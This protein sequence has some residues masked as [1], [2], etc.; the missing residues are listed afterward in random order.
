[1]GVGWM[2][3]RLWYLAQRK[4]GWF[5]F[6]C[7]ALSWTECP[8]AKALTDP[9]L[10]EPSH[11]LA[12]RREERGRFFFDARSFATERERFG[13]W[14][15]EG[16]ESVTATAEAVLRGQYRFFSW[17]DRDLG[18]PPDWHSNL[19]SGRTYPRDVHWSRIDDFA[20]GDVKWPWEL[21]RFPFVF[22]LVRAYARTGDERYPRAF[23]RLVENWLDENPPNLG[24]N[25]KCGQEAALRLMAWLVGLHAFLDAEATTPQLV[26][27]LAQ[28]VHVTGLRIERNLAYAISQDSNH[29]H[30]EVAGLFTIG[31]LFPEFRDSARWE[32]KGRR[33][34][35]RLATTHNYPEGGGCM[36]SVTYL[37]MMVD[38][39][40]WAAVLAD[41]S[42]R[43]LAPVVR[44][45]IGTSAE[46]L[47]QLQD[48]VSGEVPLYGS[49]DGAQ[50]LPLAEC[51]YLDFRPVVQAATVY[52]EGRRR[53]DAGPWDER[54]WWMHGRESLDLPTLPESQRDAS[55][56]P[57]GYHVLR[58]E[59]A[60]VFFRCG[61]HR[62]RPSHADMLQVDLWWRG[63]NVARDAGSFGYNHPAPYE[64][65][66]RD[67]AFHNTVTVDGL[68]Q[69]E[70][71]SRFLFAPWVQ[72]HFLGSGRTAD[73]VVTVVA[74]E[75][76]GYRRLPS[77]VRH[78]RIVVRVDPDDV[79]VLDFLESNGGHDYELN[80]LVADSPCEFE[81]E[82]NR[83]TLATPVGPYRLEVG[84]DMPVTIA[85]VRASAESGRG[86]VARH[87]Q[88]L[89]P[90]LALSARVRASRAVLWSHWGTGDGVVRQ[91][92]DRWEL[93]AAGVSV[94]FGIRTDGPVEFVCQGRSTG[95][96]VLSTGQVS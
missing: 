49:N 18:I 37:R 46:W 59:R 30:T 14:R 40:L 15:R 5:A 81:A 13:S 80:W 2:A 58:G 17:A 8:L 54:L 66:F 4:L 22:D 43:P 57:S 52:A 82:R 71:I 12:R 19:A 90:A 24:V 31:L 53:Y 27:R 84:G 96:F 86:W 6:R 29:G 42:G 65:A 33:W 60:Q 55:F 28:A 36:N 25:W 7:P 11:F 83:L 9:E 21:S 44:Q 76:D 68:D 87:Y 67:T 48:P 91:H 75:H 51:A 78:R 16:G 20:L 45:R 38:V 3:Y 95:R 50:I 1:M 10:A 26:A 64:R 94:E 23:W 32:R 93:N 85:L 62:H 77:P 56:V 89:E 88:Q 79:F 74:G 69:M 35:E 41:K 47:Y 63:Q 73:G 61:T 39:L 34:L 72:G 92:G 70:R